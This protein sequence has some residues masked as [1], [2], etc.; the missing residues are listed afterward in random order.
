MTVLDVFELID[1][2]APFETQEEWDNSGLLIGFASD[3]VSGVLFALDVTEPVIREAKEKKASLLV[4]HHP[5]MISPRRSV[6]DS[7]MEGRLITGLIQNGISLI[8]AHTNLDRATGGINDALAKQ[9]GLTGIS[10]AGFFRSGFL[11][12]EMT[13]GQYVRMIEKTLS[14]TVR[15]MGRKEKMI[16]SV[17]L[18]SGSGGDAWINALDAG[19]DVFITGEMKHHLAISAADAGI[20]VLECGHFATEEPGIRML[21]ETLQNRFNKLKCKVGVYISEIPAYSI[22]QQP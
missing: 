12:S 16:H 2:V 6:T 7:D 11:S 14:C 9:C 15:I 17:G 20:T 19:C 21:A 5:L 13:V 10:G 4:T 3:P 22:S 18:S 8:S 1:S